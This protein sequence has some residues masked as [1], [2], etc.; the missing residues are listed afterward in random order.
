MYVG[1]QKK[2]GEFSGKMGGGGRELT[3]RV[4]MLGRSRRR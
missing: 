4:V 1:V 3:R 2:T